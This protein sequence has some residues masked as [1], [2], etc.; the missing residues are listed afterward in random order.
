V[1][2]LKGSK[3]DRERKTEAGEGQKIRD[4]CSKKKSQR[5]GKQHLKM[6]MLQMWTTTLH[7][8]HSG[9]GGTAYIAYTHTHHY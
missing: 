2:A 9:K 8:N 3:N 5:V 4:R 7:T 1:S 6:N